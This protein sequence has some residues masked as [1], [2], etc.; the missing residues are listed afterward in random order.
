MFHCT[1]AAVAF[2][3]LNETVRHVWEGEMTRE[4]VNADMRGTEK[5][6]SVLAPT[7]VRFRVRA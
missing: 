5:L 6:V 1:S 2:I 7:I 4:I 3:S